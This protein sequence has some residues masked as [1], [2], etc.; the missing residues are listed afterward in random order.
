MHLWLYGHFPGQRPL[1]SRL[2]QGVWLQGWG[3][4]LQYVLE[5]DKNGLHVA[6]WKHTCG[7]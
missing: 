1:F 4:I 3:R 5:G 2:T 7:S 6:E